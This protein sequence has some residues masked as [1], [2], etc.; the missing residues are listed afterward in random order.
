VDEDKSKDSGGFAGEDQQSATTTFGRLQQKA[1]EKYAKSLSEKML[2]GWW[3]V[4]GRGA[5]RRKSAAKN[6]QYL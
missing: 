3:A 4:K 5:A 6:S 2:A 1:A